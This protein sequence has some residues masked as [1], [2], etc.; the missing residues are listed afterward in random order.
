VTSSNVGCKMRLSQV[1]LGHRAA[2]HHDPGTA[3]IALSTILVIRA[4][5]GLSMSGP[6]SLAGSLAGPTLSSQPR[7]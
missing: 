2:A 4:T 1:P 6:I 5:L 7:G 3:A